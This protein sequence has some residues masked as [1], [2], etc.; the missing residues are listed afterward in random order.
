MVKYHHRSVVKILA[1]WTANHELEPTW[2][3]CLCL[4]NKV[5][6]NNNFVSKIAYLFLPIWPLYF[7]CI[8]LYFIIEQFSDDRRIFLGGDPLKTMICFIW[9]FTCVR[10]SKHWRKKSKIRQFMYRFLFI[11]FI[12]HIKVSYWLYLWISFQ[13]STKK[14]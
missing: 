6:E 13:F 7:L 12:T 10:S 4:M 1:L 9:L 3:V 11:I 2:G 14:R 8:V 5:F